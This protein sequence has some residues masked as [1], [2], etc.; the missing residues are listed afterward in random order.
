VELTTDEEEGRDRLNDRADLHGYEALT[1]DEQALVLFGP[2]CE[3][4][5]KEAS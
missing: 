2:L 4:D 1:E 3:G 5:E